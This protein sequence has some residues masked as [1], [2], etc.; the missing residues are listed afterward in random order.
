MTEVQRDAILRAHRD[1]TAYNLIG[2]IYAAPRT[3]RVLH[4]NRWAQG[5]DDQ[6]TRAGLIAAGINMDKLHAKALADWV[7]RE[8]D[9]R[10][11][12]VRAEARRYN[13]RGGRGDARLWAADIC[14]EAAHREALAE[15]AER[16]SARGML[17]R[18][19]DEG[20][21][22]V[23]DAAHVQALTEYREVT[24]AAWQADSA[25]YQRE[26]QRELGL[27]VKG[28]PVPT[29]SPDVAGA[30]CLKVEPHEAHRIVGSFRGSCPGI[31]AHVVEELHELERLAAD[32]RSGGRFIEAARLDED[33]AAAR[34]EVATK[35]ETG[36]VKAK[37]APL[38]VQLWPTV[39]PEFAPNFTL[40]TVTRQVGSNGREYVIWQY[41]GGNTRMFLADED[42]AVQIVA[43]AQ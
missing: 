24:R 29:Q 39:S 21:Q 5:F 22:A 12:A 37:D 25:S 30:Q 23:I 26:L 36:T 20:R 15:D 38:G 43:S 42:V 17:H 13:L 6:P 4:A 1:R 27:K 34:M 31:K 10:D 14:R 16:G 3:L 40:D 19:S 9:A 8:D 18:M 28:D 33:A 35:P 7:V 32:A 2:V 41:Q 11:D